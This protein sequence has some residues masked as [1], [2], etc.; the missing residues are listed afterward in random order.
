AGGRTPPPRC[1]WCGPRRGCAR[2]APRRRA[3]R[4]AARRRCSAL[5]ALTRVTPEGRSSSLPR[6]LLERRAHVVDDPRERLVDL[7]PGGLEPALVAVPGVADPG[8]LDGVRGE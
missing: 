1:R 8:V 7:L 4:R 3:P 5:L 2:R 6:L